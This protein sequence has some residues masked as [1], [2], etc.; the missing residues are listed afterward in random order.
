MVASGALLGGCG[1]DGSERTAPHATGTTPPS[2]P[3]TWTDR[4]DQTITLDQA[5]TRIAAYA[6]AAVALIN[7]GIRPVAIFFYSDPERDAAFD[8]VDLDGIE[9]VGT[10]YGEIDVERLVATAP[11][12]VVTTFYGTD[13]PTTM[14]GFKDKTQIETI[15][16]IA[17]ITGIMQTGSAVEVIKENEAFVASLGIDVEGGH[18]AADRVA[19]EAASAALTRAAAGGLTVVPVYAEDANLYYAKAGDD[20]ALRMYADLGVRFVPVTGQDYYWQIVS[21]ENADTYSPDVFLYADRDSYTPAQ[22]LDQPTFASLPAAAAGQ[23]HPWTFK[24]M[25]YVSQAGYMDELAGWLS[26]DT[27]VV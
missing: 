13:T 3:W 7:F 27:K 15:S 5:P 1:G 20:P 4:L 8:G 2:G 14:Y 6:D 24:A 10:A 25:D 18:V 11:D 22:L 16:R 17:P 9:V 21:W 19:F 12:L 23:L 26:T